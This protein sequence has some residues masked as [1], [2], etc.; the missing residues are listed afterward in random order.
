MDEAMLDACGPGE[1]LSRSKS[2][3]KS[4]SSPQGGREEGI[5]KEHQKVKLG[6]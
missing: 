6:N 5:C 4:F 3:S 1:A 2:Y